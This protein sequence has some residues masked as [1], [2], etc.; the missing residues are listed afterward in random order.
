MKN[1]LLAITLFGLSGCATFLYGDNMQ[2][3]GSYK[4]VT[5]GN[6][7]TPK[8]KIIEKAKQ[9]ASELCPNGYDTKSLFCDDDAKTNCTAIVKCQELGSK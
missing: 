4:I 9:H 5:G 6:S 1:A 8:D 3:D 2:P 7:F